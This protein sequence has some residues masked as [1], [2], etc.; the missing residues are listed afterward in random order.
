MTSCFIGQPLPDHARQQHIRARYV[1]DA[2]SDPVAIA[3]I[4]LG[5]I[6]IQMIMTAVLV[7]TLHPAL[8]DTEESFDGIGVNVTAHIFTNP[9]AYDTVLNEL[10]A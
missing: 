8:E 7:N 1:V 3:E 4:E 2:I 5:Q 9:V 10:A 6:A